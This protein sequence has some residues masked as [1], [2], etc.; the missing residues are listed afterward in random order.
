MFI[1]E[2]QNSIDAKGRVIIPSKFR[3]GLGYHFIL[4]KGFD[5]CLII[6]TMDEWERFREKLSALPKA[7]KEARSLVRY[8]T[9]GAVECELDKQGR[10]TIPQN[11]RDYARINKD[12]VTIGTMDNVEIWSKEVYDEF[13]SDNMCD[14]SV[15][16]KMAEFG[17]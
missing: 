13:C 15:A 9:S 2:Y 1:G 11:L 4:T 7:N 10:L 8:V 16:E 12:L 3:D 17:I 5:N 6:Y 14:E